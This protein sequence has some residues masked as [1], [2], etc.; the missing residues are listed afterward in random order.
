MGKVYNSPYVIHEHLAKRAGPHYD[1]RI[2]IPGKNLLASF[3]LPKSQFPKEYGDKVL[4]I[5]TND[6]GRYWLFFQG[7]IPDGEYGAGSIKI[8]QKGNA[9]ILGWS[10]S[11]ITFRIS[12]PTVSGRFTLIKFKGKDKA[13]TWVLIRTKEKEETNKESKSVTEKYIEGDI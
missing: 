7:D 3:A 6:H 9:E 12:G 8:V 13:N 1:F 11:Y 5:R 2:K 4:A 10:S